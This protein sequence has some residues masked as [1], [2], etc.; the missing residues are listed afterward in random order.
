ME[1]GD[2]FKLGSSFCIF[3]LFIVTKE[4]EKEVSIEEQT[5][6]DIVEPLQIGMMT[7][8]HTVVIDY[9]PT[10]IINMTQFI[11]FNPYATLFTVFFTA[12]VDETIIQPQPITDTVLHKVELTEV[13][14]Q[15]IKWLLTYT[16][17]TLTIF[18]S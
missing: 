5:P 3:P 8:A 14:T 7:I 12:P 1:I 13:D 17:K 4:P 15:G 6:A 10:N 16:E 2:W 9:C 11:N 18:T